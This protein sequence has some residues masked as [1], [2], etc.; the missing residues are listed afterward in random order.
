MSY[1]P[2]IPLSGYAGWAYLKRTMA[3]Q[4]KAF[5]A[6]PEVKSDEA[7][8]RANIGKVK[9]A[10]QLVQ[11]R[12]LLKVALGAFGLDRDIENKFFIQKVL[13]DGTLNTGT[14][15][16][17]LADKQYL[18]LSQAFGFG[19][20]AVPS[21]QISSF[22]DDI[23]ASYQA[24][25]FEAAV[26][27]QNDD[28]RLA[29]N[30]Q[31]ELPKLAAKATASNNTKWFTILGNAPLRRVFEKALGLPTSI[32][33]LDLDQ[34]LSAF[35]T[36]AKAQLGTDA[37]ADFSD[38]AKLEGLMRRFLVRSEAQSYTQSVSGN[39]ALVLTQQVS[40]AVRSRYT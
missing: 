27:T 12:R 2:A 28:L 16:N 30:A 24:R 37:I 4:T 21:T 34:Q 17:K 7:Y 22:A 13:Q 23:V 38:P 40:S 14:L 15:A 39:A 32:G 26:G 8:F 31:R 18:K 19:D 10:A 3:V 36:K 29:L 5:N 11:D 6:A 35:T 25:Q 20:Y 33:A 9:T 1:T